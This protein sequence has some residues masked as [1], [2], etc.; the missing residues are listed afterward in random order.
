[1]KKLEYFFGEI[2]VHENYVIAIMK[3]GITVTP[4]LNDVLFDIVTTYFHSKPFV[5]ITNRIN[6]YAVDP[7]IYV[8]TAKIFNLIGFA[9]VSKN[10]LAFSNSDIEKLFFKKPFLHFDTLSE[11]IAWS[12]DLVLKYNKN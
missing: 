8:E 4:D 11:A 2:F 10:N 5:Y 12:E 7:A 6:S 9:I 3:E 1:M